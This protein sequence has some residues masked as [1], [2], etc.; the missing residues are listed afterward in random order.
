MDTAFLN[1]I[2]VTGGWVYVD[3]NFYPDKDQH[4]WIR[5][6]VPFTFLQGGR[7]R[8]QGGDEYVSVTGAR[9]SFTRQ[10]FFRADVLFSQEPWQGREFEG[11]RGADVRQH[12]AVP[13]AAAVRQRQL[14]ATPCTTTR[15]IRFWASR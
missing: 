3:Y 8:I 11:V 10:G 6:I 9:L 13:L 14:R 15:S 4:S 7:D 12:A 5:R 2:G 1:R